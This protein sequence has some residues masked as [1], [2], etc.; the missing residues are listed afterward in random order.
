[1][2]VLGP[3]VPGEG[4]AVSPGAA[5]VLLSTERAFGS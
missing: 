4:T 1:M 2:S 3:T 5:F